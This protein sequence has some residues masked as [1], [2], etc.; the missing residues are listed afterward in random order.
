MVEEI[1]GCNE[2]EIE[3]EV[4]ENL[5]FHHFDEFWLLL[6]IFFENVHKAV[7]FFAVWGDRI[8]NFRRYDNTSL[9][10]KHYLLKSY[11]PDS[12]KGEVAVKDGTCHENCFEI[13]LGPSMV[14]QH[15][16]DSKLAHIV[17]QKIILRNINALHLLFQ[18]CKFAVLLFVHVI[19]RCIGFLL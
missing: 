18:L 14:I 3:A 12:N 7:N 10:Q 8:H 4:V 6:L 16:L 1:Q 5:L 15:G 2:I 19:N 11:V 9:R 13:V 17:V